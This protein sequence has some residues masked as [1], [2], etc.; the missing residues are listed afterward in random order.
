[1]D[2]PPKSSFLEPLKQVYEQKYK[3]LMFITIGLLIFSLG[4]LAHQKATTGEFIQKDVSLKG[5]LIITVQTDKELDIDGLELNLSKVLGVSVDVKSLSAL[6]GQRLG[7]TIEIEKLSQ[8]KVKAEVEKLT[9]VPSATYTI[10]ESSSALSDAFFKSI[11][12]ALFAA[13]VFMS[14]VVFVYFRVPAPSLAV[15]LA[16]ASDLIGTVAFMQ[17]LNIKL[18]GAGVAA[19]LML[20]G[21]SVDTDILLST[22]VLRGSKPLMEE[23]YSSLKT[24]ITMQAT[25]IAALAVLYFVAPAA[26]LRQISVILIIG[27][28]LDVFNTWIQNVGLLRMYLEWKK[29]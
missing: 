8:D 27:L 12:K 15:I 7:Y 25:A 26:T 18:S 1:M 19:L 23:V 21:Y 28:I 5:G 10:E 16:A 17:L 3:L 20:I 22:R 9:G 24:G 4:V 29:K 13:F 2:E 11:V 14:I 6:A